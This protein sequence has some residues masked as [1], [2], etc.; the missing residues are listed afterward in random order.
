MP[1]ELFNEL[2][3]EKKEKIINIGISEF[4]QY[5]YTNGSTNRIV[6]NSSIS[7]GSLF[8]YFQSKEEL[9]LYILEC[10]SSELISSIDTKTDGLS[11]DFFQRIID[12]SELEFAWY[13]QNPDKYKIIVSAFTKSD[14]EIYQKIVSRY[15]P[16]GES[17]YYKLLEDVDFSQL[18]WDKSKT[19]NILKWFLIG[20]NEQFRQGTEIQNIAEIEK[21]RSEYAKCLTGY[22]EIL[23]KG[24][25]R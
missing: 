9:Y 19:I 2:A 11:K 18:K 17:I 6:K 5:G 3:N 1:T 20:F 8:Q 24:L 10:I 25:L 16:T 15:N 23:K 13:V 22:M 4:A 14:T 12:Y 7:K 21:L